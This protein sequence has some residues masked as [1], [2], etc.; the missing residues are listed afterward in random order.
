MSKSSN[1][2]N[3]SS[4]LIWLTCIFPPLIIETIISLLVI[5]GYLLIIF[6]T[7]TR[8]GNLSTFDLIVFCYISLAFMY[9]MFLFFRSGNAI[10]KSLLKWNIAVFL[11]IK[12]N[13]KKAIFGVCIIAS[14]W[15]FSQKINIQIGELNSLK[16]RLENIDFNLQTVNPWIKDSKSQLFTTLEKNKRINE[17]FRESILKFSQSP[18]SV[19]L[20]TDQDEI[21]K[22]SSEYYRLLSYLYSLKI[23]PDD[24]DYYSYSIDEK[25]GVVNYNQQQL[26]EVTNQFKI[27][28]NQVE[29]DEKK[30]QCNSIEP[31][32]LQLKNNVENAM[33]SLKDI[34]TLIG[35]ING[36]NNSNDFKLVDSKMGDWQ[37]EIE[38]RRQFD[39]TQADKWLNNA[40]D[41]IPIVKKIINNVLQNNSVIQSEFNNLSSTIKDSYQAYKLIEENIKKREFEINSNLVELKVIIELAKKDSINLINENDIIN[42]T[43][44]SV[45]SSLNRAIRELDDLKTRKPSLS[46]IKQRGYVLSLSSKGIYVSLINTKR[47]VV[48]SLYEQM[49]ATIKQTR[50]FNNKIQ[51]QGRNILSDIGRLRTSSESLRF[52]ND[53][54]IKRIE[55]AIFRVNLQMTM[56]A[57]ISIFLLIVIVLRQSRKMVL[58]GIKNTQNKKEILELI[59]VI[60]NSNEFQDVRFYAIDILYNELYLPTPD[61]VS[62]IKQ[63][64]KS[65]ANSSLSQDIKVAARLR[66]VA[67]DLELRLTESRRIS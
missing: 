14:L 45:N 49:I 7:L 9:S 15:Y 66:E 65:I 19:K 21:D 48:D 16:M 3:L 52:Q 23:N 57:F 27:L 35:D 29:D 63:K 20:P 61:N 28:C 6:Y 24:T 44:K 34:D 47:L 67:R 18:Y 56:I 51:I 64:V 37:I 41:L 55:S 11:F 31:T 60:E 58:K 22:L 43:E 36:L 62:L 12:E 30:K 26:L 42:Q 8:G 13:P 1:K 39:S 17:S 50:E 54:V 25:K 5:G 38:K 53:E 59:Q 4:S 2:N 40:E 33:V 46:N 10:A 32:L